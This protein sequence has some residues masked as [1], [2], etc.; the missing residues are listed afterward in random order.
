MPTPTVP[1]RTDAN[2]KIIYQE[3]SKPYVP[4]FEAA[5]TPPGQ[6]S[7]NSD[8]WG[9]NPDRATNLVALAAGTYNT[10]AS[11]GTDIIRGQAED[12][13]NRGN[14]ADIEV[15][16]ADSATLSGLLTSLQ[17]SAANIKTQ[18]QADIDYINE[19][20]NAAGE[21]YNDLIRQAQQEKKSGMAKSLVAAG[22]RGGLM[23]TQFAGQAAQAPTE[24]G[25]FVGEGGKLA[26]IRDVYS[27][28]IAKLEGLKKQAIAN[29][30][31]AAAK[32]IR[33]GKQADY[34]IAKDL[35][36]TAKGIVQ[37]SIDLQYKNKQLDLQMKQEN[38]A[39]I[40]NTFDIVKDIPVGKTVTINGQTFTG[41]AVPDATKSFFSGSD[42]VSLMKALPEGTS[43]VMVDPNTGTKYTITG[44]SKE[45]PDYLTAT[46]DRGNVT[47]VD[48]TTLQ[49]VKTIKGIGKT[50]T[51][52]ANVT[53]NMNN[54]EKTDL[55]TALATLEATKG[56]KYNS[57]KVAE[58]YRVY[59]Q[60][61]PG[62]GDQLLEAI[63][64]EVNYDDQVI[65]ELYDKKQENADAMK[66]TLPSGAVIDL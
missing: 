1:Y 60:L 66:I 44:L 56:A 53:L 47:F 13:N 14:N 54:A 39:D 6:S 64:A 16:P 43:Q 27:A 20:A 18:T 36:E 38:R 3:G 63:K 10:P 34:Q 9:V 57:A 22:E 46:D 40:K 59:N 48:K 30:K 33:E 42:I 50:K 51:Q 32:F 37:D 52:A 55:S 28:N 29:A 45:Q 41:I 12:L 11:Q 65:K 8:F 62:K 35:Y 15:S 25:T 26:E 58:Q 24:G 7:A 23:N 61:H 31:A 19:Q 21:E 5:P 49:P 17:Q 4:P 2:G